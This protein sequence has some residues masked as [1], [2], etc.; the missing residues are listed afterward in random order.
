M[1][2]EISNRIEAKEIF[3]ELVQ[4]LEVEEVETVIATVKHMIDAKE[5]QKYA[6]VRTTFK[7]GSL[8]Q[9]ILEETVRTVRSRK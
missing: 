7:D 9:T 8:H 1:S 3:A 5:H 2:A 4:L 6:E